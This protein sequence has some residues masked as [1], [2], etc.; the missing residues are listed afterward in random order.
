M[1]WIKL[2]IYLS[3]KI[4]WLPMGDTNLK[5]SFLV[6]FLVRSLQFLRCVTL[7]VFRPDFVFTCS[8]SPCFGVTIRQ[9]GIFVICNLYHKSIRVKLQD[10]FLVIFSILL[11]KSGH[12]GSQIFWICHG[13]PCI[14]SKESMKCM[15]VQG[16][17]WI[18]REIKLNFTFKDFSV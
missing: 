12:C 1:V 16:S 5:W 4:L 15:C 11:I 2:L 3:H 8:L 10:W 7:S 14:W 6:S 17:K 9:F 18:H 13:L